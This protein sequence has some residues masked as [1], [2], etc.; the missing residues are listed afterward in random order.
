MLPE[1]L[2]KCLERN[3]RAVVQFGSEERRDAIDAHLWTYRDEGFLPHGTAKDGHAA[4]QPVWLTTGDDNPNGASVRF[5]ADGAEP[6]TYDGYERV[7]VLF[8]GNDTDAVDRARATWQ[9]AK[10]AGHDATYWQQSDAR[11]LGEEGV[12]PATERDFEARR[13]AARAPHRP[14]RGRQGRRRRGAPARGS[15]RST[16]A[17]AATRRRAVGRPCREAGARRVA[18][19]ASR[20]R[21]DRRST[22]AA[23]LAT[24]PRRW[25]PPATAR[26]P[27]TCRSGRSRGRASAFRTAA[28]TYT[29]AD[30][31]APPAEWLGAFDLVNEVYIV[32]ALDGDLRDATPSPRSRRWSRR[33]AGCSSPPARAPRTPTPTVRRGR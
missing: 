7:V 14:H 31:F 12:S 30:M 32:Q 22:S 20:R 21:H 24:T 29:A 18:G 4:A 27:S 16:S 25:P 2:E 17:P 9:A 33:A 8:D 23:A 26:P 19:R 28:V 1:L 15:M 13:D 10:A 5:M 6:A 11:P 3:W